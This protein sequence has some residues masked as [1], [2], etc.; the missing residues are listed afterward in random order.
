MKSFFE[1]YNLDQRSLSLFRVLFGLSLF[2]DLLGRF[3]EAPYFYS[4]SGMVS[5]SLWDKLWGNKSTWSIHLIDNDFALNSLL[6]FQILLSLLIIIG[7]WSRLASLL[8][9]FLFL[10]LNFRNPLL[11][12]G[13]DKL[14]PLILICLVF[15]PI[16]HNSRNK[17]KFS[18][19]SS[20]ACLLITVQISVLYFVSGAS[21]LPHEAWINGEAF[22]IIFSMNNLVLP[23][24]SLFSQFGSLLT[25]LSWVTPWFEMISAVMLLTP[26]VVF[27]GWIRGIGLW[28]LLLT[29]FFIYLTLDVGFFMHYTTATL[30]AFIPSSHWRVYL[31]TK[32]H[33][34]FFSKVCEVILTAKKKIW[35]FIDIRLVIS[36]S[37]KKS[38]HLVLSAAIIIYA[39][40]IIYTGL[41]SL[42][43]WE[44][45]DYPPTV[46]KVIRGL[47]NYQ[48]WGLFSFLSPKQTWF[49]AKA[50]LK[51]GTW[52]DILQN[53]KPPS[54]DKQ[55]SPNYLFSENSKW[56]L[57]IRKSY[58]FPKSKELKQA[59]SSA[60][61]QRWNRTH[62]PEKEI[63]S[64]T[65]YRLQEFVKEGKKKSSWSKWPPW[66][67]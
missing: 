38:L 53:G 12:Y 44:R 54:W 4:D 67:A 6:I 57:I 16:F 34:K 62:P 18:Y 50:K 59:I 35:Q 39:S 14:V 33:R 63:V 22:S 47:N 17:G 7:L 28:A 19:L 31:T 11:H 48:N 65:F 1:S 25:L 10:S 58:T 52:V 64:M 41:E 9:F 26:I 60:L 66:E 23:A 32:F 40:F 27:K 3:K 20:I 21:K 46:W 36:R 51:D 8:S 45:V 30:C 2:Y 55:S 15:L 61:V 24:A 5:L 49:V 13:G 56:R 37:L 43:F 42:K 29:N